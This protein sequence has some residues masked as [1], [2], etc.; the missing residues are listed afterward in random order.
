[1]LVRAEGCLAI[2]GLL[3]SL[4]VERVV[5]DEA[6]V[7]TCTHVVGV[8]V[9]IHVVAIHVRG[10]EP[11]ERARQKLEQPGVSTRLKA[12]FEFEY[13]QYIDTVREWQQ[14]QMERMQ[15]QRQ[16]LAERIEAETAL[17]AARYRELERSLKLQHKRLALLTAA[18]A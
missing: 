15:L 11:E 16:K 13:Q 2:P 17:L 3:P 18:V 5:T 8:A 9:L 10:N 6:L 1:M 14:L 12:Q 4:V 7:K